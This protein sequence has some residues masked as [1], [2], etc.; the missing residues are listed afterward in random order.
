MPLA[1]RYAIV[2]TIAERDGWSLCRAVGAADGASVLVERLEGARGEADALQR[3]RRELELASALRDA[4]V[5]RPRELGTF[6]GDPALVVDDFAGTPLRDLLR[7]P[8]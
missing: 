4:P 3:L 2:A 1:A 5:L 6:R 8:L 7:G